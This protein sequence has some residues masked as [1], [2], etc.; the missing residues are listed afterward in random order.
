MCDFGHDAD[1][2]KK[3]QQNIDSHMAVRLTEMNPMG[4]QSVKR[5]KPEKHIQAMTSHFY[6]EAPNSHV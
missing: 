5:N 4:S 2:T 3:I 6:L 1:G